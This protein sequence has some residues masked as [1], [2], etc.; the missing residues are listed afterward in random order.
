MLQKKKCLGKVPRPESKIDASHVQE[1]KS[2]WYESVGTPR[3]IS[4]SLQKCL[5]QI[6]LHCGKHQDHF[7]LA[8]FSVLPLRLWVWER[9]SR[10]PWREGS[11]PLAE[12]QNFSGWESCFGA[13][14]I[15]SQ[16][17]FNTLHLEITPLHN[18][19]VHMLRNT[20]TLYFSRLHNTLIF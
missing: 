5:L 4:N 20:L 17:L 7:I 12:H 15:S 2:G 13:I 3:P 6:K 19:M 8:C 18:Q 9:S 10:E 11:S 1:N 14:T 16:R